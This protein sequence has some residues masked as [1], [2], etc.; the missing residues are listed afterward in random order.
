M[1]QSPT[2]TDN[3]RPPPAPCP[4]G[5]PA[6]EPPPKA[7]LAGSVAVPNSCSTSG[8]SSCEGK[9]RRGGLLVNPLPSCQL[10][11]PHTTVGSSGQAWGR[12]ALLP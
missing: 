10:K 12:V 5:P 6:K 2:L 4:A 9:G 3:T 7:T 8:I 11:R 1:H